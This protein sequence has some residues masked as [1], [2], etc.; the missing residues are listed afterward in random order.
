VAN[1]GNGVTANRMA[2]AHM[3]VRIPAA[4]ASTPAVA[5]PSRMVP[6]TTKPRGRCDLAEQLRRDVV[7]PEGDG[8]DA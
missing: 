5:A 1:W 7:A 4:V 2:R 6:E 3:A 8:D